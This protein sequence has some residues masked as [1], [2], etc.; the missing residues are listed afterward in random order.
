[1]L[2]KITKMNK[3]VKVDYIKEISKIKKYRKFKR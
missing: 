2:G 1:M 3:N